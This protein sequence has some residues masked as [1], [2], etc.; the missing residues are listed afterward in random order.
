MR[1]CPNCHCILYDGRLSKCGVCGGD[2]PE[3]LRFT[4]QEVATLDHKLEEYRLARKRVEIEAEKE[5]AER[6][7]RQTTDYGGAA[8]CGF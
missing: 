5:E 1:R 7:R 2:V 8:V 3:S 6:K 4:E